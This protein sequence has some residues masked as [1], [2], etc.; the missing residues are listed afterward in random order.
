VKRIVILG[1]TGSIGTQTLD[2]IK[3]LPDQLQV[4]GLSA[5]R[6]ETL[7]RQQAQEFGVPKD[8]VVLGDGPEL[9]RI[10]TLAQTDMVVV[11]VAGFVGTQATLAALNAGK[12]VALATKEV[13][14]AAGEIVMQAARD[15]HCRILPIDSEHSAI[16]QC[17]GGSTPDSIA[18][19][20][21][22]ASGGPFRAPEWTRERMAQATIAEALHHPTWPDM[23]RMVLIYSATLMN[24]ALE[25]IEAHWLFQVPV[26]RVQVVIH[27]QSVVHSLVE[28]QDGAILAQLG[29]PDMRLP[30]EYALLY[31]RRIDVQLPRLNP[32]EMG[33]LTFDK[34]D[35]ARFP[36]IG[37]AR[38]AAQ[39]GGTMPAVLN[40]ANEEAV[41]LFLS[42]DIGF[43][44]ITDLV[45]RAMDV[46]KAVAA[47]TLM[48][49]SDADMWARG[50]V[51]AFASRS[52][53]NTQRGR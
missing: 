19:L 1:S 12:D 39:V 18:N 13:L 52:S 8:A 31:P 53:C 26:E 22:T 42:E 48:Q 41:Q 21:I 33:T 27:P 15:N 38:H 4:V 5:Y 14:V 16:F 6:N 20:W 32:L 51:R 23:G 10:A 17:L 29:L 2:I 30:I 45:A 37:Y 47:P 9:A 49:I 7:L 34:P 44:Q 36:A 43:G 35:E 40:A 46:H 28:F 50:C 24:K 11:A 3:R 25:M